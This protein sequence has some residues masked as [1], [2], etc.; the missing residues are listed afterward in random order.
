MVIVTLKPSYDNLCRTR[1]VERHDAFEA[2]TELY[3]AVVS[4]MK[5]IIESSA[6]A[7]NQETISGAQSHLRAIIELRFILALIVTKNVLAYTKRLSVKL[8]GR[9]Q[10]IIRAHNNIKSVRESLENAR[11]K[12]DSFYSTWFQEAS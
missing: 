2:F 4:C 5:E 12:G 1:W 11:N 10:D 7:W 3:E 9:W 6:T 8:Q